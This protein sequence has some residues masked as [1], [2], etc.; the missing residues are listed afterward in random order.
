[1]AEGGGGGG[2]AGFDP[3]ECIFS[4]EG[5]MRRLISLLRNTQSYCS[6]TECYQEFPGPEAGSEGGFSI[7]LMLVIWIALAVVLFLVRP[8]SMR[9]RG[10]EKPAP[11]NEEPTNEPPAPPMQ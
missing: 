2:G 3:C 9:H 7:G 10:D 8:S 1:M 5:A 4:H 11:G 6:D